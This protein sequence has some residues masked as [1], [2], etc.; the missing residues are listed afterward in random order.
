MKGIGDDYDSVGDMVEKMSP[1]EA[2]EAQLLPVE[3]LRADFNMEL[4]W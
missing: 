4:I 1:K 3:A 2:A